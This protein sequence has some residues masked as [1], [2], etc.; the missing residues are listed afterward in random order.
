MKL[1]TIRTALEERVSIDF[2]KKTRDRPYVY[3]RAVY[4]KLCREFTQE[5]FKDIGDS[6]G[7]YNHATVIHG[8]KLFD[9]VIRRHEPSLLK[10]YLLVKDDLPERPDFFDDPDRFWKDKIYNAQIEVDRVKANYN[11]VVKDYD[12]IYFKAAFLIAQLK[13]MGYKNK[14]LD[15]PIKRYTEETR[16]T[17]EQW[18]SE[19][20][21]QRPGKTN[22][23][24][25]EGPE[26][27]DSSS[28]KEDVR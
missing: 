12:K 4:F 13:R 8:E 17:E 16:R 11:N 3:V 9:D 18:S 14:M 7:G 10:L 24:K 28:I 2:W 20:S 22:E 21:L 15:E 19:G 27:Y 6:I 25:G 1:E 5:T 23:G 26:S